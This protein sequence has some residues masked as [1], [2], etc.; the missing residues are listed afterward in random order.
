MS[1][2]QVQTRSIASHSASINLC[3]I[4]YLVLLYEQIEHRR[5]NVAASAMWTG[6]DGTGEP[7]VRFETEGR[8]GKHEDGSAKTREMKLVTFCNRLTSY[9]FGRIPVAL[10]RNNLGKISAGFGNQ[11]ENEPNSRCS[12]ALT[13]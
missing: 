13:R 4:R 10:L 5:R 11:A 6:M 1:F 9:Q 3:A 8:S 12:T 7:V 2:F